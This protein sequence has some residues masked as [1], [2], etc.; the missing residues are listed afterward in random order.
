MIE[1]FSKKWISIWKL[2]QGHGSILRFDPF[3]FPTLASDYG[4]EY[5]EDKM[6]VPLNLTRINKGSLNEWVKTKHRLLNQISQCQIY[7]L[8]LFWLLLSRAHFALSETIFISFLGWAV[9]D[10]FVYEN[11]LPYGLWVYFLLNFDSI[12]NV[13]SNKLAIFS[14]KFSYRMN[15]WNLK[16]PWFKVPLESQSPFTLIIFWFIDG[17]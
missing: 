9:F 1:L 5:Y 8:D 7:K 17:Y 14:K 2:T 4:N 15:T 16:D 6:N 11:G 12:F 13:N 10:V 3:Y